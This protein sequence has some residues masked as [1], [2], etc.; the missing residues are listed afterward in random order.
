MQTKE[1]LNLLNKVH[2]LSESSDDLQK[3]HESLMEEHKKLASVVEAMEAKC[4]ELTSKGR[5]HIKSS[6][7]VFPKDKRYPIHDLAH[8]RNALARSSGKP[9][10]AKVKAA[11]YRKYPALKDRSEEK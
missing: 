7:F 5:K 4:D 1:E 8:A 10:E 2:K 3:K 11:V 6:N 9:E